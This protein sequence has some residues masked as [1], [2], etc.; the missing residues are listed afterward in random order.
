ME[1]KRLCPFA[2]DVSI[3][4]DCV[5]SFILK[6]DE[7][8]VHQI[9]FRNAMNYVYCQER[10]FSAQGFIIEFCQIMNVVVLAVSIFY[11]Q[12]IISAYLYSLRNKPVKQEC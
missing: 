10:K 9:Q 1:S 12:S 4:N 7:H 5:V 6:S 2:I 8:L 11:I 3:A